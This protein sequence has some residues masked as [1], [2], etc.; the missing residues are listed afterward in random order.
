M[1]RYLTATLLCLIGMAWPNLARAER[2]DARPTIPSRSD[3]IP[4]ENTSSQKKEP[5]KTT[6]TKKK[7]RDALK[8]D[9]LIPMPR[10]DY[11]RLSRRFKGLALFDTENR[12]WVIPAIT[13]L[14][15]TGYSAQWGDVFTSFSVNDRS[16]FGRKA[17]GFASIGFGLGD[18][19]EWFGLE[20]TLGFLNV[21]KLL[22]SG[23]GLTAK[24]A[25]TFPD[26]TSIAIGKIDFLQFPRNSADTGS[27]EYIAVSKAF[28]LNYDPRSPFS[29]L[30]VN[31][32]VG[33]GQFKSDEKFKSL[34]PGVGLFG[35]LSLRILEPVNII[36]NWN[37]NLHFGASVAPFRKF[38][39]IVTLGV[40]DTLKTQ[41]D[42][43]RYVVGLSYS[44]SVFSRTFPVDWF[45]KKN[46]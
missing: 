7:Y 10:A 30:V 34:T 28:I 45:K 24:L 4:Q 44:D 27:S 12:P 41:G 43:L 38:P 21:K 13:L 35:S 19:L 26:G 14:T 22:A 9:W 18:P 16:R 46:I 5:E 8:S 42:G 6:G 29:L 31:L 39:F 37:H 23:K 36:A 1:F 20:I 11:E 40:L 17:D 2:N 15:P 3:S 32:G 25:H 33:D